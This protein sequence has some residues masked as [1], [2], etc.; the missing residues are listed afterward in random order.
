LEASADGDEVRAGLERVHRRTGADRQREL[1]ARA[2]TPAGFVASLAEATV[3]AAMPDLSLARQVVAA[4]PAHVDAK[5]EGDR[6]DWPFG[7][8]LWSMIGLAYWVT[9]SGCPS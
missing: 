8:F 4:V 1:W 7:A 5:R 2:D 9:I 3:P 6:M